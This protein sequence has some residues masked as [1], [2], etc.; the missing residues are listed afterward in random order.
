[1]LCTFSSQNY[2]AESWDADVGLKE[3]AELAKIKIL[4]LYQ[5]PGAWNADAETA[6][7]KKC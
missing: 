3:I 5:S 6:E 2:N 7:E 1:M 4:V